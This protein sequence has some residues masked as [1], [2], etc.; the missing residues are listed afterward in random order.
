MTT[1]NRMRAGTVYGCAFS[2]CNWP[3]GGCSG[4]CSLHRID[5]TLLKD[6]RAVMVAGDVEPRKYADSPMPYDF[7]PPEPID[8]ASYRPLVIAGLVLCI[9]ILS[10]W[11]LS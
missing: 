6:D 2:A 8:W 5:A 9:A 10:F 4:N 3:E 1:T 7:A 11:R